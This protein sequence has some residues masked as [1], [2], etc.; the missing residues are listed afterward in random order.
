M[1]GGWTNPE[2]TRLFLRRYCSKLCILLL[3]YSFSPS[4]PPRHPVELRLGITSRIPP[5]SSPEVGL[6]PPAE[7]DGTTPQ[8]EANQSGTLH[9][10]PLTP[11][12]DSNQASRGVPANQDD[13]STT[14]MPVKGST[15]HPANTSSSW[16]TTPALS[17]PPPALSA[18]PQAGRPRLSSDRPSQ[19]GVDQSPCPASPESASAQPLAPSPPSITPRLPLLTPF[20]L[21]L[22]IL[23]ALFVAQAALVTLEDALA[24][25]LLSNPLPPSFPLPPGAKTL[26][27][28]KRLSRLR[29][30]ARVVWKRCGKMLVGAGVVLLCVVALLVEG[31]VWRGRR[32]GW[33]DTV[34]GRFA[35][36]R[37]SLGQTSMQARGWR[38][39]RNIVMLEALGTLLVLLHSLSPLLLSL[40][41]LPPTLRA[42]SF[43]LPPSPRPRASSLPLP[44]HLPLTYL[45]PTLLLPLSLALVS[46]LQALQLLLAR[47]P[48]YR[49]LSFST[50]FLAHALLSPLDTIL[51]VR[52][53][54]ERVV[55][56]VDGLLQR[57]GGAEAAAA[58]A[59][60]KKGRDAAEEEWTCSIC[61]ESDE[62]RDEG[63]AP[64]VGFGTRCALPC[65][66][67]FHAYCLFTW[68]ERQSFCPTCHAHVEGEETLTEQFVSSDVY[69]GNVRRGRVPVGGGGA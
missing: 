16:S 8:A 46:L 17:P 54:T 29:W 18:S 22:L 57:F 42:P 63:G 58:V 44:L 41:L 36:S 50:P 1:L 48:T 4:P 59:R 66:H 60:G 13:G 3:L 69:P 26:S 62:E 7:S 12:Y 51:V 35:H 21:T 47:P 9:P 37:L 25:T 55:R 24:H 67:E 45:L 23:H 49:V 43:L 15:S 14:A 38:P 2:S 6:L 40:S 39:L 53:R 30:R 52:E 65:R 61:F 31:A 27:L 20:L 28:S 5:T 32:D 33:N 11:T 68:F 34:W 56:G 10:S 19:L 64:H